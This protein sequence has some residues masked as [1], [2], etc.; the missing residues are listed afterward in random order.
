MTQHIDY[1]G[2]RRSEAES[3]ARHFVPLIPAPLAADLIETAAPQPGEFAVDV[4]C[5]TG[6]VT[7][8]VAERVGP[9]GKVVGVDLVQE[10]LDVAAATPSS[11]AP[12]D[13]RQGDAQSLPLPDESYDLALCQLGL[14]FFPDRSAALREILRVLSPG[15][16][17]VVNVPAPMPRLFEIM[18]EALGRHLDPG[19]A[20]FLRAVFSLGHAQ[21]RD[22]LTDVGFHDVTIESATKTLELPPPEVFLWRYLDVTPI[23]AVIREADEDR[24]KALEDDV[25]TQWQEFVDGDG[26]TLE[27]SVVTA[28]ARR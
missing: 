20:G 27:V 28:A 18:G 9:T 17:F 7:R 19:L 4:A 5:G 14:M 26:L 24:R 12:I 15:G 2:L 16:R 8:L 1:R 10:M 22:L 3:Y 23:A 25:V 21:L 11:G 6:V 13:W